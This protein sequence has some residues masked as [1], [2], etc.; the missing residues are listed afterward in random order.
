[1]ERFNTVSIETPRGTRRFHLHQ[2][3]IGTSTDELVIASAHAYAHAAPTGQVVRALQA[4]HGYDLT[5][6]RP[7]LVPDRHYGTY[8]ADAIPGKPTLMVVRI[9]GAAQIASD[10]GEPLAV[11]EEALWTLFGSLA[12]LELRGRNFR[13]ISLPILAGRQ[14]YAIGDLLGLIL[15]KGAEWLRASQR[16]ESLG[17]YVYGEQEYA[18]WYEE[19]E[20]ILGRKYFHGTKDAVL[21][22][23]RAEL[24]GQL[25]RAEMLRRDEPAIAGWLDGLNAGLCREPLSFHEIALSARKL[26]EYCVSFLGRRLEIDLPGHLY[27]KIKKL[28]ESGK[29]APWVVNYLL[30]LKDFGNEEAHLAE[31]VVHRPRSIHQ[32]DVVSLLC[33]IHRIVTI[34]LEWEGDPDR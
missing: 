19:M 3:D 20:R 34:R 7:L 24:L 5:T 10:G 9:P 11:F 6:L 25:K 28:R 30:C 18:D 32:D 16:T 13:S 22:G 15:R 33:C 8:I 29:V 26:A 12:A 31:R 23:L 14:G 21:S 17:L 27:A 4:A 2:G 1:M